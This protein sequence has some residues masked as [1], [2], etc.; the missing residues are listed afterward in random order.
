M[1][2]AKLLSGLGLDKGAESN[3]LLRQAENMWKMLDDL[4]E[5][6]PDGYQS[7][8]SNNIKQGKEALEEER[9][10]EVKAFTRTLDKEDFAVTLKLDFLLK[11]RVDLGD[12]QAPTSVVLDKKATTEYKGSLLLSV[13]SVKD[14]KQDLQP[15]LDRF[16]FRFEKSEV[17]CSVCVAFHPLAAKGLLANPMT[18]DAKKDLSATLSLLQ[19]LIPTEAKKHATRQKKEVDIDPRLHTCQLLP[20]SLGKLAGYL[21]CESKTTPPTSIVLEAL[22]A[23]HKRQEKKPATDT[24]KIK[25]SPKPEVVFKTPTI[26]TMEEKVTEFKPSKPAPKIQVMGEETNFESMVVEKKV[27]SDLIEISI[28]LDM[29]ESLAEVD[30][31]ISKTQIRL[32]KRS[33]SR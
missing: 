2:L 27:A 9:E 14:Q 8:V 17:C 1:D 18:Q 31:D 5:N 10:A 29:I 32:V 15:S 4:A 30:L 13:F 22:L 20:Q 26:E 7:F 11:P 19:S 25:P 6:N 3:D 33:P 16:S 12:I 24:E 23:E 28:E 21:D